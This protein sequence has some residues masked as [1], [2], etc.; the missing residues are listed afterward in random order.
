MPP[1]NR[2]PAL[3]WIAKADEDIEAVELCL[4]AKDRLTNVAAFHA[5]QAAEKLLKVLIASTGGEPPRTHDLSEL[6]ERASASL[7]EVRVLA[8]RIEGI[9]SWAVLTRYPSL[10]DTPPP[11][12]VEIEA[13][14]HP[15]RQLRGFAAGKAS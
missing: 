10:G 14:L 8:E 3:S 6:T 2:H 7:P 12:A 15:I 4:T 5:Q 13:M 1:P 9:T 11:T